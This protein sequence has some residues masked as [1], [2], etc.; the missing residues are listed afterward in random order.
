MRA[1]PVVLQVFRSPTAKVFKSG[2]LG[3]SI[4]CLSAG[5]L[6]LGLIDIEERQRKWNDDIL[7]MNRSIRRLEAHV[8][9]LEQS[10]NI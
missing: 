9:S 10:K 1:S 4:G 6:T 3:F 5:L 8:K 2:L 7:D